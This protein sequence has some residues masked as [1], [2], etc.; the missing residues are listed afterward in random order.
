MQGFIAFMEK[1]F[2]P[3]AAKIG[4][5]RHL[6]A[7][8]DAFAA[9]MPLMILGAFAT[10]INNLPIPGYQDLMNKIFSEKIK[11][12]AFIW[13]TFGGNLWNGTFAVLGVLIAFMVAYNLAK[14]YGTSA[15]AAGVTSLGSFF[16]V[17]GAAGMDSSGLFIALLVAIISTEMF[18]RLYSNPKLVI[19]MPDSVPPAVATSFAALLPSMITMSVLG[20]IT[21]FFQAAHVENLVTSFYAAVQQPFMGMANTYPTALLLAF[22]TPF[23]WFFGLHGANMIDPFMQTINAPAIAAN[24]AALKAGEKIPYIVNKPLFDSFVNQGGTGL[25]IGLIIAIFLFARKNKAYTS[26]AGLSFAPGLFNINEPLTFGLPIVL[27]PILLIPYVLVPMVSITIAYFATAS[28]FMPACTVMAPWVTPP[29]IGGI[30][31]TASWQ[32]GVIAAVNLLLSVVIYA[33][34]VVMATV[35]QNKKDAEAAAQNA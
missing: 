15:A 1:H 30:I 19:K 6:V 20:L 24:A 2:L 7:I 16:V 5:Q 9:T 3:I 12:G 28:G 22:I 32:G 34:F 23:L 33:P 13:T 11:G 17:G 31:S 25:T 18:R 4:N 14:S 27:N 29:I 10:L 35:V 26:I 21:T 8:R